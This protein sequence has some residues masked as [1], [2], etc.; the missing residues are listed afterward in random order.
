MEA[1]ENFPVQKI[2]IIA[3]EDH[4]CSGFIPLKKHA[5]ISSFMNAV[6]A[7]SSTI[8]IIIILTYV[9]L[10]NI[11][12]TLKMEHQKVETLHLIILILNLGI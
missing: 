12:K 7:L 4:P 11:I 5:T 9:T 2:K 1:T 3:W 6:S 8:R 10:R